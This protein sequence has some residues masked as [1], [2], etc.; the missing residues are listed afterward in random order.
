[1]EEA[2][3]CNRLALMYRGRTIALGTP[4]ELKRARGAQSV[5]EVFVASIEAEE[6]GE[7]S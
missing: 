5:E 6:A 4:L 3:Y 7:P 2:E 1:M